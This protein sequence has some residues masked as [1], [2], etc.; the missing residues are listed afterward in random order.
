MI[1]ISLDKL[2]HIMHGAYARGIRVGKD[3]VIGWGNTWKDECISIIDCMV[4]L[5]EIDRENNEHNRDDR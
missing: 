3:N 5:E 1:N 2:L 4:D